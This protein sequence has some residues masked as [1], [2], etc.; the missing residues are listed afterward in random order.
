MINNQYT[1]IRQKQSDISLFIVLHQIL[2]LQK[3]MASFYG[4]SNFFGKYLPLLGFQD[5]TNILDNKELFVVPNKDAFQKVRLHKDFF[6]SFNVDF[7]SAGEFQVLKNQSKLRY[8]QIWIE[9][10]HTY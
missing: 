2:I 3:K 6:Y 9:V 8:I 10:V 7:F 4:C 1:S 5:S